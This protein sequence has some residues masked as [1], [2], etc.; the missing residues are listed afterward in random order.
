MKKRRKGK[1]YKKNRRNKL[2][3]IIFAVLVIAALFFFIFSSNSHL[4]TNHNVLVEFANNIEWTGIIEEDTNKMVYVS[5]YDGKK[6]KRFKSSFHN[7]LSK[8]FLDVE[9]KIKF[10]IKDK[11]VRLDITNE[12]HD[13]KN[14][15]EIANNVD[16]L[17]YYYDNGKVYAL[18]KYRVGKARDLKTFNI[19]EDI[20]VETYKYI[21]SQLQ[22]DGKFA[23]GITLDSGV[24]SKDY[25]ILRHAGTLW[26]LLDIYD[27]LYENGNE[28]ELKKMKTSYDYLY[29]NYLKK[30]D[31]NTDYIFTSDKECKI[32]SN[33]LTILASLRFYEITE[34]K[35]YLDN[36]IKLTN[37]ILAMQD[38]D[39]AF[40]HNLNQN[41][42]RS[43]KND[44]II[45][46]GEINF[47]L[48]KMYEKTNNKDYLNAVLKSMD[49]F[50]KENNVNTK[51]QWFSY[52]YVELIKYVKD[53]K[54]IKNFINDMATNLGKID[55]SVSVSDMEYLGNCYLFIT[56]VLNHYD[57]YSLK[58]YI[59]QSDL[60]NLLG[61][62][63]KSYISRAQRGLSNYTTIENSMFFDKVDDISATKGAFFLDDYFA[64]IDISQHNLTGYKM[65]YDFMNTRYTSNWYL[66]DAYV[67]L[68]KEAVEVYLT[69]GKTIEVPKDLPKEMYEKCQNGVFISIHNKGVL[70]GCQ[71][72]SF[73]TLTIAEEIIKFSIIT[74]TQD[75][76]YT[77][78]TKSE[79]KNLTYE[80][81]VLGTFEKVKD[82]SE[83]DVKKY[84]I[85][86]KKGSN[87]GI[88]MPNRPSI[89]TVDD[90][91]KR[92]LKKAGLSENEQEYDLYRFESIIYKTR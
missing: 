29:K 79:L 34:N 13:E 57:E 16:T 66:N 81:N 23:Y 24:I 39:G 20:I 38:I 46:S 54:Y 59:S 74:A 87:R 90:Q 68:A 18:N 33:A 50:I 67:N 62:I 47:V 85:V 17:S 12:K 77:P 72:T 89:L 51:N 91:I 75:K 61:K 70:R 10:D 44:N 43:G 53:Y 36:S 52:S 71:G 60:N 45:Y 8:C 82:K 31:D 21:L 42:E 15:L 30:K 92:T 86:V 35:E 4:S 3:L 84:G 65:F 28:N 9:K 88:M 11:K 48:L 22:E 41:F 78:V 5:V 32:G 49:Y 64:R 58:N 63:H 37:G 56:E 83:L 27:F 1:R 14:V 6:V 25:N 73:P 7:D 2:L 55:N 80:V 76:R 69:T 26:S 19:K 40:F